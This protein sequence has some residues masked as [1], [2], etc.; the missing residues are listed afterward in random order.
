MGIEYNGGM[1]VGE[2]GPKLNPHDDYET[3]LDEW[4]AKHDLD[5][6]SPYFDADSEE[7]YFGFSVKD[8]PV[9]EIKGEWLA[10]VEEKA[11]KF[12]KLTGVDARLIG[13]QDIW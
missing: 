11:K 1:I 6:M 4:A 5:R 3:D 8:V 2:L 7:C 13:T 10:D 9:S 12:K